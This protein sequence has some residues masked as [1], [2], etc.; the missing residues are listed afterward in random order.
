VLQLPFN[1]TDVV[2]NLDKMSLCCGWYRGSGNTFRQNTV[3]ASHIQAEDAKQ[4]I[5]H[6]WRT[7]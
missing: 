6:A 2:S 5:I 3:E 7:S 1:F 4:V